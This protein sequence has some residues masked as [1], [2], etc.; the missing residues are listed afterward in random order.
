[1]E[2]QNKIIYYYYS[3]FLRALSARFAVINSHHSRAGAVEFIC[4]LLTPLCFIRASPLWVWRGGSGVCAL[5]LIQ[6]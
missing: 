5:P 6:E 1:M 2:C 4:V 3:G